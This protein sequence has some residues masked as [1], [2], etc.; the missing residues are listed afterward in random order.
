[1]ADILV[2]RVSF[3]KIIQISLD[4]VFFFL[5]YRKK[6]GWE[7]FRWQLSEVGIG[8]LS[9]VRVGIVWQRVVLGG[10]CL[11][12]RYITSHVILE[13]I[14]RNQYRKSLSLNWEEFKEKII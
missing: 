5:F 13:E 11:I 6:T 9:V 8:R 1:M 4:Y 12:T 14:R 2:G 3:Y 10:S 7:L